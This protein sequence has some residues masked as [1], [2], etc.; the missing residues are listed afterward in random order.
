MQIDPRNPS[1]HSAGRH[2]RTRRKGGNHGHND[3]VE[4]GQ[5]HGNHKV[6]G[7]KGPNAKGRKYLRDNPQFHDGESY[8][9]IAAAGAGGLQG[10]VA[11][12]QL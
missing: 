9:N 2:N 1:V 3:R 8:A 5:S 11:V 6:Y 7:P 10:S 12:A 4:R